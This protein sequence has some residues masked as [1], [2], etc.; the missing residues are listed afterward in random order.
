MMFLSEENRLL[1]RFNRGIWK[2]GFL[3]WFLI[4]KFICLFLIWNEMLV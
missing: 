4:Y 2:E 3:L 1:E